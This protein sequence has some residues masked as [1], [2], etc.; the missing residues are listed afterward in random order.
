MMTMM[1]VTMVMMMMMVIGDDDDD[2]ENADSNKQSLA[3]LGY[4]SSLTLAQGAHTAYGTFTGDRCDDDDDDVGSDDD[5]HGAS[6]SI[7]QS[8]YPS[9]PSQACDSLEQA[10][11]KC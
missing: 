10:S 8:V 11:R 7:A 9:P 5:D 4:P 2:D 3:S 1:M 6:P